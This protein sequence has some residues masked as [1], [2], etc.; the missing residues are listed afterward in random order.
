MGLDTE[1][2]YIT[3]L[4]YPPS[5]AVIAAIM[6]CCCSGVPSKTATSRA[7]K[8]SNTRTTVTRFIDIFSP[9]FN[10]IERALTLTCYAGI[11]G[12]VLNE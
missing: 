6:I 10:L 8:R 12:Q 3:T 9:P 11:I 5:N 2:N 4:N 1:G 7:T